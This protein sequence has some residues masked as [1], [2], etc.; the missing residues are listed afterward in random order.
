MLFQG[1]PARFWQALI[2]KHGG[3]MLDLL[4]DL[5]RFFW[6]YMNASDHGRLYTRRHDA[7]ELDPQTIEDLGFE[8]ADWLYGRY[9]DDRRSKGRG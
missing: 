7:P 8:P 4:Q 5:S 6:W 3:T 9:K 2:E 1:E